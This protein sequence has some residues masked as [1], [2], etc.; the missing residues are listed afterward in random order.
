MKTRYKAHY[1]LKIVLLSYCLACRPAENQYIDEDFKD[2]DTTNT[3]QQ[4]ISKS[5]NSGVVYRNPQVYNIDF[6]FELA[7]DP[8]TIDRIKD[9]KLWVPVPREWDSQKAVRIISAEPKPN[10]EYTDLEHGNRMFYWDFGKEPEKSSYKVNLKYRLECYEVRA[11]IDPNKI[12]SYDITSKEY[13]L[14]T[15]STA[16]VSITPKIRELARQAVGDEKNPYIQA[17]QI[18][19]F[20][21]NKIR[22]KQTFA[23]G[24]KSLLD[25]A[26]RDEQS[27]EE[28]YSGACGQYNALFVAM[29]RSVGIP[30]RAVAGFVGYRPWMRASDL[31]KPFS[32]LDT[33]QS[34]D[35]LYGGQHYASM[36]P[37]VWSEFYLPNYGWIPAETMGDQLGY[38]DNMRLIMHKGRDVKIGPQAPEN[39]S[40]GYGFQWVP[41]NKGRADLFQSGVWNIAGIRTAKITL[42]CNPDPFPADEFVKYTE[43]LYPEQQAD[44]KLASYRKGVLTWIYD[45]TQGQQDKISALTKAYEESPRTRYN[46]KTFLCHLLRQAVGDENF[47]NIFDTYTNLRVSSSAPVS[48]SRFKKIAEDVYS[49]SLNWFFEQWLERKELP[50]LKLEDINVVK[51]GEKWRTQGN[52]CQLSN[53]VFRLP[54][55]IELETEKEKA[56]KTIW[57]ETKKASFE[58]SSPNKPKRITVDPKCHILKIQTMPLILEEF[59]NVYPELLVVYGTLSE[60]QANKAAAERFNKEYL[61]LDDKIINSDID[62]NEADLK[63]KCLILF[64]RPKTNKIA[65]QFKDNFPIKFN[66]NKFNWQ[67]VT[68][69]KPTQGVAQIVA[70]P[71]NAQGLIIMYAGLSAKTTQ[72]LC[73]LYLYDA[74]ASYVIFEDNKVSLHGD[75]EVESGLVWRPDDSSGPDAAKLP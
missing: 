18:A 50:E 56:L 4:N 71:N 21:R 23:R 3:F 28:Y 64:G 46:H 2:P 52:L 14:Y 33:M 54:V 58:F 59:W 32:E 7:P 61:G 67:G 24:I 55:E 36:S 31:T 60:G 39:D 10:A 51:D 35:G 75:W 9:L 22:Y 6:S 40:G 30:A 42:L 49:K 48:T 11:E 38:W 20:S 62:V 65:Q 74:P 44:I 13:I 19:E 25:T 12:G 29:C 45:K 47:F 17:K 5:E 69:D 68:Y 16:T 73:D 34:P 63:T 15:R 1:I 41:L 53:S 27:G 57:V 72:T 26:V 43:L 37:H 8:N 70:N 66:G